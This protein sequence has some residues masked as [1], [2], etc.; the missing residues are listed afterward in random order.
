M[1]FQHSIYHTTR[2]GIH[3]LLTHDERKELRRMVFLSALSAL[4]DTGSI[5]FIVWVIRE[6][7]DTLMTTDTTPLL[8]GVGGVILVFILKNI[9]ITWINYRQAGFAFR[10]SHRMS[11]MVFNSLYAKDAIFFSGAETGSLIGD[12]M[13]IPNA[14]AN[15]IVLGYITL[16]TEL[17]V[18]VMMLAFLAWVAFKVSIL[19]L[20]LLGPAALLS[21]QFIK[22]RTEKLGKVR[23]GHVK[24]AQDAMVQSIQAHTDA[25]MYNRTSYFEE[26][27]IAFQKKISAIDATVFT[28]TG[29]PQRFMEVFAVAAV[30]F[31]FLFQKYF[32]HQ[33]SVVF[34][35]TLFAASAFRLL[36]S[37][38][39]ILSSV[40]K[41][42][43]HWFALDTL[44]EYS[45]SAGARDEGVVPA[46]SHRIE[47]TDLQ[48]AY[49]AKNICSVPFFELKKGQCIGIYGPTGE[50]KSTFVQLLMQLI[51]A[52]DGVIRLDDAVITP[53]LRYR[54]HQLFA[55]IKQDVFILNASLFKNITLSREQEQDMS[56][57]QQVVERLH[58]EKLNV[59]DDAFQAGES[60][61]KVSG[62]QKK[63][64][65][66]ARA[67]YHN[68]EVLVLDEV[69]AS[70]DQET[71]DLV[72]QVLEEEHKKGKTIILIS[73]Q[74]EVFSICDRVYE[75]RNG[76]LKPTAH[77]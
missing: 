9:F 47:V 50:G 33:A 20:L 60:G 73:H 15:G 31:I 76:T 8:L 14:F 27:F 11:R 40:L 28:L 44:K 29:L 23:S 62:G 66:L 12:T 74:R 39:R 10:M 52:D 25:L 42:K 72:M 58:L 51:P 6:V 64:I 7:S 18:F 3:S 43:N 36:P 48:F 77:V 34:L 65:A 54:Y 46:F 35:V 55:Y 67:I 5:A 70:L 61:N 22:G 16:L 17:T 2:N 63:L 41:I 45:E 59:L 21:Y 38:N 75:F 30:C 37:V 26:F 68:K 32:G 57:V 71:R 69:T 4:L 1:Q 24:Q 53:A 56:R 19:M 13:Y 49:D